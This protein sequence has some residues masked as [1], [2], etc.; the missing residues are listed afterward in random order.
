MD[1]HAGARPRACR[2]RSSA[3][4]CSRAAWRRRK[5]SAWRP[6]AAPRPERRARGAVTRDAFVERSAPG[7]LRGQARQ[8]RAGL[9]AAACGGE[10]FAN[11]SLDFGAIAQT[12]RGGCIIRS[13]FL[14]DIKKAFDPQSALG[15]L[16]LDPFFKQAVETRQAAWRRV[17]APPSRWHSRA[18]L[19]RGARLLDGYRPSGCRRIC[20]RRSATISGR[21]RTSASILRAASF[22]HE[23]DGPR[24]RDHLADLRRMNRCSRGLTVC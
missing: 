22:S 21:I 6:Q 1:G 3:R 19:W 4:P 12:W 9:P 11:W 24:R 10:L 13:A 2:S 14:G 20:C 15:N 5:T 16:L 23:L 8:L 17:V 18:V 7:A